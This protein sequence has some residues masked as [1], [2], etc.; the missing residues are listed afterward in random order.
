VLGRLRFIV[1]TVPVVQTAVRKHGQLWGF[2]RTHSVRTAVGNDAWDELQYR[3]WAR[4]GAL[5]HPPS[6]QA[7]SVSGGEYLYLCYCMTAIHM[8]Y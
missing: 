3:T 4:G 7:T 1:K 5:S 6:W 2:L 8:I